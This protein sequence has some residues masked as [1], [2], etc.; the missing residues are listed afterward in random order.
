MVLFYFASS[1]ESLLDRS[2]FRKLHPPSHEISFDGDVTL[3]PFART[4]GF[5]LIEILTREK[6]ETGFW[7][8]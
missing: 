8:N 6:Q 2:S 3:K 7:P 5:H 1:T 4:F